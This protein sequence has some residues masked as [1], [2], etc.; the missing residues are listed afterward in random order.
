[1][2]QKELSVAVIGCGFGCTHINELAQG[3]PRLKLAAVCD[4]DETRLTGQ[5]NNPALKGQNILFTQDY[6]QILNDPKIDIVSLA[7]P[8]H[9]HE[10]FAVE[11]A[12]AGK[13]IML[14]KPI[15]RTLEEAD[16]IIAAAEK[17]QIKLMVAFNYRYSALYSTIQKTLIGGAIGKVLLAVTRHYQR[18]YYPGGSNWRNSASVGGGCIMGSGVHNLDMLRFCMGEPD[19]VFAY[20][21]NDAKRLD[22]EAAATVVYK[23]ANGAIV[24]FLCNWVKSSSNS[25]KDP[26]QVFGQ[27]EFYGENGELRPIDGQLLINRLDED[28]L[29]VEIPPEP[30]AFHTLWEHFA[31][32]IQFNQT[33]LTNGLDAKASLQ[34]VLKTYESIKTGKP[35]KIK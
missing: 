25:T 26:A 28:P 29:P 32:C 34:L 9:L 2:S 20:A 14:D 23:Y 19:E 12:N 27:W 22:A 17:N 3:H 15:A 13:H 1:M 8:H 6:H 24:N 31:D 33:P 4:A 35:V 7:L 11:T 16:Q 10:R 18:F 30:G 21:V 5:R